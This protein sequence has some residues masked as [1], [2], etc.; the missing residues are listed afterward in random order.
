[1]SNRRVGGAKTSGTVA[2]D[3]DARRLAIAM[4]LKLARKMAGLSQGQ[5]ARLVG[6]HRPSISEAE[7]GRRKVSAE[8]LADFAMRYGVSV[9]WLSGSTP[10]TVEPEDARV[11]LAARELSKLKSQDLDRVLELLAALRGAEVKAS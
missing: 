2:S 10:L 1:M 11:E 4:R 5:V 9:A 7:A 6:L 3:L 8:E